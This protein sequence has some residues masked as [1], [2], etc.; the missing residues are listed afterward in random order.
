MKIKVYGKSD[1]GKRKG[2]C[3]DS[4]GFFPQKEVSNYNEKNIY[5]IADGMGGTKGGKIASKKAVESII[6]FFI[7]GRKIDN[8]FTLRSKDEVGRR[9]EYAILNANRKLREEIL[10]H[11]ELNGMG[12]TV[13]TAH[14]HNNKIYIAHLGDSRCYRVRDDTIECLTQ[15]HSLVQELY[16]LGEITLEQL[17]THPQ[18]H[19][20]TQALG[21]TDNVKC[22]LRI[23]ELKGKD[24]FLLCSDGINNVIED[25]EI[26]E[27]ILK[28]SPDLTAMCVEL[29]E[30][31]IRKETKDDVTTLIIQVS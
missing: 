21:V 16:K 6:E 12:T 1:A 3:E 23:E 27:I 20:I 25:E 8:K 4:F 14:I 11:P 2:I 17:K 24:I 28:Q 30:Q 15:D 26:K 29:I 31:A 19:I 9:L 5:I 18:R 22:D 13:V 10:I 7:K